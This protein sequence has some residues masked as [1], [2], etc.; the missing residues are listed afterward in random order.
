ME[1]ASINFIFKSGRCLLRRITLVI[2][3][4]AGSQ[5][6]LRYALAAPDHAPPISLL[7]D[8]APRITA[9]WTP[10]NIGDEITLRL[11]FTRNGVL[12][13]RPRI[14]FIKAASGSA[15]GEAALAN[16]IFAALRDCT[17]LPF[18]PGLGSAVAGRVM[19]IRFIARSAK[20]W[21]ANL[22]PRHAALS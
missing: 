19:T 14:T 1:A 12:A 6:W 10:P 22:T 5:A 21:R 20:S 17:P 3:C 15:D 2:I 7:S 8:I 11:S 16:S 18:T 13:G 4:A 9:C